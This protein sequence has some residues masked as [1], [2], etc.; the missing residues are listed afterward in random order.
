MPDTS[1]T[2][3]LEAQIEALIR[4]ASDHLRRQLDDVRRNADSRYDQPQE[5]KEAYSERPKHRA[6]KKHRA[7]NKR[8]NDSDHRHRGRHRRRRVDQQLGQTGRHRPQR[9]PKKG[10]WLDPSGYDAGKKI[11][12]I[13]SGTSWSTRWASC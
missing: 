6:T 8:Q 3:G 10:A 9:V 4:T 11:K 5:L 13:A 12:G 2:T 7:T 1:E